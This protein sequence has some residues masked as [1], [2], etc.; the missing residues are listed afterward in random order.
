MALGLRVSHSSR[1][2]YQTPKRAS[3][4]TR[5]VLP[6]AWKILFTP[7]INLECPLFGQDSPRPRDNNRSKSLRDGE[8]R[9]YYE[10]NETLTFLGR[11][12]E[13]RRRNARYIWRLNIGLDRGATRRKRKR[14]RNDRERRRRGWGRKKERKKREGNDRSGQGGLR[15]FSTCPVT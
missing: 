5:S 12:R 3:E 15:R 13:A 9:R 6:D 8:S 4:S 2:N 10:T 7:A 1:Y 14:R 11:D